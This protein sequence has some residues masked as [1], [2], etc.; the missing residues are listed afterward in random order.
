MDNPH[1]AHKIIAYLG[2]NIRMSRR[3]L[4]TLPKLSC[5]QRKH[6]AAANVYLDEG[7]LST[8]IQPKNSYNSRI[9]LGTIW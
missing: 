2:C 4:I 5:Y 9:C 8:V 6:N 7:I 3:W 1:E